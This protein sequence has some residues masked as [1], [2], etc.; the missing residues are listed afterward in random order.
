MP[1][2]LIHGAVIAGRVLAGLLGCVCLY[3][4]FFLY[5]D[6]EGEW[7]NRL[8]QF[9]IGVHDRARFTD[10]T[11]VAFFNKLAELFRNLLNHT[12][13]PK[14]FS[15]RSIVAS[16]NL[17]L[18]G[19][20]LVKS[21]ALYLDEDY[22]RIMPYLIIMLTAV[23]SLSMLTRI[24]RY[25]IRCLSLVFTV[26]GIVSLGYTMPGFLYRIN[27]FKL[28]EPVHLL[29]GRAVSLALLSIGF[30]LISDVISVAVVRNS[31]LETSKAPTFRDFRITIGKVCGLITLVEGIPIIALLLLWNANETEVNLY[32]FESVG[33]EGAVLVI[34]ILNATTILYCLAPIFVFIIVIA[35][36]LLWPSLSRVLYPLSRYQVVTNRKVTV[37][38]GTVCLSVAFN[39]EHIGAK[40]LLKLLS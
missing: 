6:E 23:S 13:G 33:I 38:V 12:F 39:L 19:C 31:L 18:L 15:V 10:S 26:A 1:H 34:V 28:A 29:Y 22:Y 17:S 5:E 8:D 30:S 9:W 40:E 35:H 4:A 3:L 25:W 20:S 16:I 36:K 37:P 7:Q 14:L 24:Q 32:V 27:K 2:W 11:S 21:C